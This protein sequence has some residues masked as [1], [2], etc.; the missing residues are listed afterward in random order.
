MMY[1]LSKYP[2][3]H[4]TGVDISPDQINEAQKNLKV[5]DQ[6]SGRYNLNVVD[7]S[8]SLSHLSQKFDHLH[9]VWVLEHV[10]QPIDLLANARSVLESGAT[11]SLTEVFD[12]SLFIHPECPHMN[13]FWQKSMALKTQISGDANMGMRLYGLLEQAGYV[14]IKISPRVIYFD[15]GTWQLRQTMFDYWLSLLE[16]GLSTLIENDLTTMEE[17][18]CVTKEVKQLHQNPE[19]TFYYTFFQAEA[20]SPG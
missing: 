2:Y 14:D 17:W 12:H 8:K 11:I 1:L 18:E 20:V 4:V 9:M 13:A 10:A 7:A 15:A 16:S 5:Y 19:S 3:L 6:F